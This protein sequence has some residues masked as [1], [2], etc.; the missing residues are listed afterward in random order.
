MFREDEIIILIGAG[1]SADAGIPTS[2]KMINEL[3]NLLKDNRRWQ[4]FEDLYHLAKSSILYGDGIKGLS[5]N[6]FDI[7]RLVNVLSELEKKE[8]SILYPFIGSWSPRLL[9]IAG[10][11][12][13]MIREFKQK[14][15]KQLLSW[16]QL[17]DYCKANYYK[18]FFD[19]QA[20]YTYL[21]RIFSL[22]YD[23]CLE[24]NKL[25]DKDIERGFGDDRIWDW[26][27]FEGSEVY[28]PNIYLYKMHGSID[29]KRDI[30][31]GNIVREVEKI[32]DDP[33]L[34]FGTDYK[35]QYIDPYLFYAYELRK[36]SLETKIILTVGYSFRDEHINGI[37][38]QALRNN[39]ERKVIVVSPKAK[40]I[41]DE[42]SK[43]NPEIKKQ[44][45]PQNESAKEFFGKLCISELENT[46]N[47]KSK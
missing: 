8:N 9:E 19:F 10:Y 31:Q 29:W 35:M 16:V 12:F 27:R 44:L 38:I 26:R 46:T 1:C 11:D 6:N 23:L 22:N 7:E 40:D 42:F 20:E 32:P 13:K 2:E 41:C 43:T 36:Y 28:E 47:A 18:K 25:N 45:L 15:L 39:S 34:I 24:R 4:E 21:L 37:L 3:E 14:I 5:R 33:D 30:S 17:D